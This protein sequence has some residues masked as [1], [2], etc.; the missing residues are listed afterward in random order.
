MVVLSADEYKRLKLMD[1]RQTYAMRD[2][3]DDLADAL[4]NAEPPAWTAEL[5]HL[6]EP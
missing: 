6:M 5:N 3:P 4:E 1:T 2:L